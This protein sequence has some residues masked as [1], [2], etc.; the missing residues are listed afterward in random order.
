MLVQ[1][2]ECRLLIKQIK[3]SWKVSDG[4][5]KGVQQNIRHCSARLEEWYKNQC[6]S[7]CHEINSSHKELKELSST[8]NPTSWVNN[9]RVEYRLDNL[10]KEDEMYWRERSHVEWLHCGDKN[11]KFFHLRALTRRSR[12]VILGLYN[13]IGVW[14]T[15]KGDI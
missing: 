1:F 6:K 8:S 2:G 11:S 9:H 5:L 7:L 14:C 13:D 15:N 3:Q 12:N 10:M 4:G